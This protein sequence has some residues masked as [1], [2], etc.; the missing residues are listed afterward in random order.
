MSLQALSSPVQ[1]FLETETFDQWLNSTGT[2]YQVAPEDTRRYQSVRCRA[3]LCPAVVLKSV[4]VHMELLFPIYV[5]LWYHWRRLLSHLLLCSTWKHTRMVSQESQSE[6]YFNHAI[7]VLCLT[8]AYTDRHAHTH[9][10]CLKCKP[11]VF[12][13][14][15][16]H[17]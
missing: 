8:I 17:S 11:A 7:F 14:P 3:T 15:L 13:Q 2:C 12:T 6:D 1:N 4:T 16:L 10:M 5:T 9:T